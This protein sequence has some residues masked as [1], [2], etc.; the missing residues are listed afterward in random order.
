MLKIRNATALMSSI[1]RFSNIDGS[2]P[3]NY[4]SDFVDNVSEEQIREIQQKDLQ[5]RLNCDHLNANWTSNEIDEARRKRIIYRSKQRG[6]LEADLL[7][8]SW[9]K[10]HVPKMSSEQLAEMELLLKE[11]T[12]PLFNYICG[13]EEFPEHL[14]HLSF[15]NSLKD[16][17][18][19][20]KIHSPESYAALKRGSNL[21]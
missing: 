20:A 12:L 11:E 21:T 13:K 4:L 7:L 10:L 2:K 9:S 15:V 17:A 14:K 5:L 3:V 8:G 16:F 19:T 1:R 6:F 18:S